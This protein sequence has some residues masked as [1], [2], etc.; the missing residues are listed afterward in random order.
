MVEALQSDPQRLFRWMQ[1]GVYSCDHR[2]PRGGQRRSS[3][4]IVRLLPSSQVL[5]YDVQPETAPAQLRICGSKCSVVTGLD[6]AGLLERVALCRIVRLARELV[7]QFYRCVWSRRV[8]G[9]PGSQ[10]IDDAPASRAADHLE[11]HPVEDRRLFLARNRL[12]AHSSEAAANA[13]WS[14]KRDEGALQADGYLAP[15]EGVA[16]NIHLSGIRSYAAVISSWDTI[17]HFGSFHT[18]L[19]T[20]SSGGAYYVFGSKLAER[21]KAG[22]CDR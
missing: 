18:A 13:R 1:F 16:R 6:G 15:P 4:T 8:P 19:L 22:R 7:H 21:A 5:R 9:T 12:L 2:R 17:R 14:M 3:R 20:G 10:K 11:T